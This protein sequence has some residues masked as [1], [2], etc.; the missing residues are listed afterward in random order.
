MN[1]PYSIGWIQGVYEAE[2]FIKFYIGIMA[3]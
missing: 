3:L 1:S 2:T